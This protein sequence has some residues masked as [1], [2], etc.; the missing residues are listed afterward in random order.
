MLTEF[1]TNITIQKIISE[2]KKV[3]IEKDNYTLSTRH[4]LIILRI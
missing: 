1:K 4:L 2:A 3:E